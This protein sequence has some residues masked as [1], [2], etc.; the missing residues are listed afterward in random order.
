P[1]CRALRAV[2][3][4]PDQARAGGAAAGRAVDTSDADGGFLLEGGARAPAGLGHCDRHLLPFF[5]DRHCRPGGNRW[6]L[7][8]VLSVEPAAAA[9]D[10]RIRPALAGGL[11][12]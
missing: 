10:P 12:S 8:V 9:G 7:V 1:V 2:A 3:F 11:P 6:R 4:G 5:L